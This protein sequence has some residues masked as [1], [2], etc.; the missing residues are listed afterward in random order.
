MARRRPAAENGGSCASLSAIPAWNGLVGP[1]ALPTIAA[2]ALIATTATASM[3]RPAPSTSSAGHERDDFLLHVLERAHRREKQRDDG[4]HASRRRPANA[5]TSAATTAGSVPRRSTTTHA[6]PTNSTTATT[7]AAATN[8]RGMAT[9][10]ANGP[11]GAPVNRVI[12]AGDDHSPA[13]RGIVA[14]VVLAG[15]KDPRQCGRHRNGGAQ[16][17]D[18]MRNAASRGRGIIGGQRLWYARPARHSRRHV[19]KRFLSIV[20][21]APGSAVNALGST[22][23]TRS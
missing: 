20:P 14:R 1:N 17:H 23:S 15:R 18:W 3:P 22:A 10:A 8:P 19:M 9:A 7:S 6:P 16:E 4:N 12:G 13:R 21:L 11:T 2:P 5:R